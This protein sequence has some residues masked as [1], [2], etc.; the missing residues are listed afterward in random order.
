MTKFQECAWHGCDKII[1]Q[2]GAYELARKMMMHIIDKRSLARGE[3]CM[4]HAEL[5]VDRDE[6]QRN[7]DFEE[8]MALWSGSFVQDEDEAIALRAEQDAVYRESVS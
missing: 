3:F 4:V 2:H 5:I 1:P 6:A 8:S 7:W